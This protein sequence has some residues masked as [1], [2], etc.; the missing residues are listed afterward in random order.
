MKINPLLSFFIVKN[1]SFKDYFRIMRITLFL[2]FVCVFQLLA[3]NTEAQ[4]SII[5]FSSNSISVGQLIEEIERQT[6]Y[7]VVYSNREIDTNRQITIRSKSAKVSAY[8]KE[9]LADLGI[10]YKFEN[11]YIIL[12]RND[13]QLAQQQEKITGTVTDAKGEPITGA[14]VTIIG[15]PIGTI[16]DIDGNFT[17]RA[18]LSDMLQV[19]FIGYQTHVVKITGKHITILLQEDEE[20]LEEIVVIGYGTQKKANLTGAT[21]NIGKDTFK[22]RAVSSVTQYLQGAAANLNII[23]NDGGPGQDASINIR[24][25]SGLGTS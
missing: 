23:N 12:S 21:A 17:I 14:N 16:T 25:Y 10:N 2:L 4:N 1:Q 8:L 6:D 9:T 20:I 11:D 22:P 13:T 5:T 18:S 19:S 24:G 7:L 15:K 3:T